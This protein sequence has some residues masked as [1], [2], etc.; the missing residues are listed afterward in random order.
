MYIAFLIPKEIR[1]LKEAGRGVKRSRREQLRS[2]MQRPP[3]KHSASW[4]PGQPP[5]MLSITLSSGWCPSFLR[6][7]VRSFIRTQLTFGHSGAHVLALQHPSSNWAGTAPP[8]GSG[9]AKNQAIETSMRERGE[10]KPVIYLF[11]ARIPRQSGMS[12]RAVAFFHQKNVSKNA[13]KSPKSY[14]IS[15]PLPESYT[16]K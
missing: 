9:V 16:Q 8:G 12:G 13:R 7:F 10:R 15:G 6:S 1:M 11:P 2:G 5:F 3:T 14:C 4:F